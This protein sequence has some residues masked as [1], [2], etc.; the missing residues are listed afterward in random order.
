VIL[1]SSKAA[2]EIAW[3]PRVKLREGIAQMYDAGKIES[4]TEAPTK[5]PL[6]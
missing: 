4:L 5:A 6:R 2:G 3:E 1:D